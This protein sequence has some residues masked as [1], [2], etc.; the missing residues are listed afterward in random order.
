MI[1]S[2]SIED[3]KCLKDYMTINQV[4]DLFYEYDTNITFNLFIGDNFELIVNN[5]VPL[6]YIHKMIDYFETNLYIVITI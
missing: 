5:M 3:Y 4:A 2:N 1:I 6:K